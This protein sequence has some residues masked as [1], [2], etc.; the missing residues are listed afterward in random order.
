LKIHDDPAAGEMEVVI[1]KQLNS[2]PHSNIAHL[3]DVFPSI[4]IEG[5]TPI[6][7]LD[8]FYKDME[9]FLEKNEQ[10]LQQQVLSW[11]AKEMAI[12]VQQ[13]HRF[14]VC[15]RN[16]RLENFLLDFKPGTA[17]H[18]YLLKIPYMI[19]LNMI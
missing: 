16:I 4:G 9:S 12:G 1:L 18:S 14:D 7:V 6:L 17:N 15:H 3:D 10:D 8:R 13:T 19:C 11:F 2:K 5:S